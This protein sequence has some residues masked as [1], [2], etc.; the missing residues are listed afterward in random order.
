MQESKKKKRVSCTFIVL[1]YTVSEKYQ[2]NNVLSNTCNRGQYSAM[3]PIQ[4]FPKNW[5][6]PSTEMS[7][8]QFVK[9]S[10]VPEVILAD[11]LQLFQIFKTVGWV[12]KW[13]P[14][15][16]LIDE[17]GKQYGFVRAIPQERIPTFSDSQLV[18]SHWE[19][20]SQLAQLHSGSRL[21]L[22]GG[23][24]SRDALQQRFSLISPSISCCNCEEPQVQ[25]SL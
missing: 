22:Q 2:R 10:I 13:I 9:Y 24:S 8:S 21:S 11:V 23:S 4:P 15:A 20:I 12:W 7:L 16:I 1:Q 5:K 19:H 18:W 17:A 25:K 6:N 3:D 14:R